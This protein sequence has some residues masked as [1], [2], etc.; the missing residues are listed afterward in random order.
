MQDVL[1]TILN[2]DKLGKLVAY[3]LPLIF[4]DDKHVVALFNKILLL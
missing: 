3:I 1:I 4:N 2:E